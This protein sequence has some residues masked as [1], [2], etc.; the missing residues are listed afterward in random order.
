M[1]KL[2]EMKGKD[3]AWVIGGHGI[4][5]SGPEY[6]S[7]TIDYFTTL[8]KVIQESQDVAT[9]KDKMAKA[10]PSYGGQALLDLLLPGFF[11]E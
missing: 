5:V 2:N 10:Y 9:A 3:W 6:F 4:P 7:K 11:K 1:A 8:G